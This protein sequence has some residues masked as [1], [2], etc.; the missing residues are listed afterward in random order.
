M[1]L[2]RLSHSITSRLKTFEVFNEILIWLVNKKWIKI[3]AK[4][5]QLITNTLFTAPYVGFKRIIS[6]EKTTL[7]DL[8]NTYVDLAARHSIE[9]RNANERL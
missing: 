5:H 8:A 3:K 4:T 1:N 2:Y 7:H 6:S 9:S